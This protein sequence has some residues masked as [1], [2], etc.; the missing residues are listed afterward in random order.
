MMREH[1]FMLYIIITRNEENYLEH[2]TLPSASSDHLHAE[3][4]L[5]VMSYY[6]H[7][8]GGTSVFIHLGS[9]ELSI[10]GGYVLDFNRLMTFEC[11]YARRRLNISTQDALS[12]F[13]IPQ[14]RQSHRR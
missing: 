4:N 10:F 7:I 11:I 3:D 5:A 9:N 14:V 1:I 8:R 13:T 12:V 2:E 6:S